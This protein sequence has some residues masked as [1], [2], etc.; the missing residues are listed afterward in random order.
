M[1]NS[2][3]RFPWPALSIAGMA[4]SIAIW[5]ASSFT[6]T[7]ASAGET[8]EAIVAGCAETAVDLPTFI[9]CTSQALTAEE[10]R[11]CFQSRGK[12]CFGHTN[13]VRQ[14]VERNVVGPAE[15]LARCH[16]GRSKE[17]VWR[18]IG[19]PETRFC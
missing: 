7:P 9:A 11:K 18:Q 17:S 14:F 19:L 12:D 1:E 4:I 3:S 8:E 15:D 5:G 6:V 16:L 2:I 10:A 13:T